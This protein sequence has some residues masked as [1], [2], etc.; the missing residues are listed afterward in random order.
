MSG[1]RAESAQQIEREP[2]Q[3]RRRS[4]S[5]RAGPGR[6]AYRRPRGPVAE[7]RAA[8]EMLCLADRSPPFTP[9]GR[10]RLTQMTLSDAQIGLGS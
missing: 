2:S 8:V 3:D 7:V 1:V 5:C 4:S 6:R 10:G 9:T